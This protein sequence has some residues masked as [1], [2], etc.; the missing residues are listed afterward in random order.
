MSIT[1]E[2]TRFRWFVLLTMCIATMATAVALISP[3]PLM[4]PIAQSMGVTLGEATGATMGAFTFCVA[5]SCIVGGALVDRFG[6]PRVFICSLLLVIAGQIAVP[7]VGTS[8]GILALLRA[9]EGA[10]TGPIMAAVTAIAAQWF[11]VHERPIVTG[12]QGMS[13]GLGI[14]AGFVVAPAVFQLTGNWAAAM[15]WLS[16]FCFIGLILTL[17]MAWG[18]RVPVVNDTLGVCNPAIAAGS[19]FKVALRQR[20][21]WIGILCVF[22]LSW[23]SQAFNDLTPAFIAVEP[24]VGIG[25]GPMEAGK[26]MMIYQIAFMAGAVASGIIT[27][28]IFAGRTKPVV[29]LGFL[30]SAVFCLAIK[31]TAVTANS[32]LLQLC[33]VGAGFFMSFVNPQVMAF[34]AK[35]YPEHITGKIGGMTMGIGIFGGTAGVIAGSVALHTTGLYQVSINIVGLVA[36]GGF[37]AAMWL[38]PPRDFCAI[39]D[40]DF[41]LKA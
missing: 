4:G 10:G 8:L 12:V 25:L 33:L 9:V 38:N 26:M 11:P 32:M 24:P 31:Y 37:I 2:Y 39:E 17:L 5:L 7:A 41:T 15:A 23:A 3:A 19:D 30:V 28:K 6:I 21:T 34:I 40:R 1:V 16:G 22:L 14:A 36:A 20:A 35:N 29:L 18:P 13:M 27:E